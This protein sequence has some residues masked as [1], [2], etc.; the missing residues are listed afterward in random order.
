MLPNWKNQ[1]FY[2][3]K[4]GVKIGKIVVAVSVY[5]RFAMGEGCH[6][7]PLTTVGEQFRIGQRNARKVATGRLYESEGERVE[8]V[9]TETRKAYPEDPIDWD[10]DVRRVDE[11]TH[12][13]L[14]YELKHLHG[15]N[16]DLPTLGDRKKI[17]D[18]KPTK[19]TL[20]KTYNF[21]RIAEGQQLPKVQ[22]ILNDKVP[23]KD[24]IMTHVLSVEAREEVFRQVS[25]KTEKMRKKS[26]VQQA[27]EKM[28]Q[29]TI[30]IGAEGRVPMELGSPANKV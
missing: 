7:V 10:E 16:A 25:I 27:D 2:D 1:I 13:E 11:E 17:K 20:E 15:N 5:L 30:D 28:G 14:V 8:S 4:R 18:L 12:E 26:K 23:F 29:L 19:T 3:I 22:V 9:F 6:E 21:L 24:Q